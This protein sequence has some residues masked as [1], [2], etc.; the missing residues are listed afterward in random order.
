MIDGARVLCIVP[1]RSGSK[2]LPGKNVRMLH[3]K[4]LLAWPIHAARASACIDRVICSTDD[5]DY[6]E[7]ARQAGADVP[8]LRPAELA[9]DTAPSLG[10]ILHAVDTLAA[11][12]EVYDYVVL[13]EPTSPLTEGAD[14][15]AALAQLH[16]ARDRADAIVGVTLLETVHPAF[17]VTRDDE[18]AISPLGGGDFAEL[19]RRQDLPPVHALDGSLYISTPDALREH[20]GFAHRRTLG[21]VTARHKALEIDDIVDFWCVEGVMAHRED[22]PRG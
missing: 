21:Y 19:P 12:D 1:A 8:F 22:L 10:F 3:G 4:P 14:V 7:L 6:A 16:A 18:G 15:D 5:P 20:Q 2:G 9:V 13:L 11:D 17:C